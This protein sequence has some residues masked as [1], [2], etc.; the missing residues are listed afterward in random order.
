MISIAGPPAQA[1]VMNQSV[2]KL[3]GV[4]F[5][6]GHPVSKTERRA[7]VTNLPAR[8]AI[9]AVLTGAAFGIFFR[10]QFCFKETVGPLNDFVRGFLKYGIFV[11][12]LT[13]ELYALGGEE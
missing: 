4:A 9:V 7:H 11:G 13:K 6:A 5:L 8:P 1:A 2:P 12:T 3:L 10:Y